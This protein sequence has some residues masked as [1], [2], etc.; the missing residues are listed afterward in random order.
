MDKKL[1]L[2]IVGVPEEH[3]MQKKNNSGQLMLSCNEKSK[4]KY[5]CDTSI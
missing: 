4:W 5:Q 2:V 3:K 1:S